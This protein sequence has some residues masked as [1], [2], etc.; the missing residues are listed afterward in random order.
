MAI[1]IKPKPRRRLRA[2]VLAPEH[3]VFSSS[4]M[5]AALTAISAPLMS[6]GSYIVFFLSQ[7]VHN[8]TVDS[9]YRR[10]RSSASPGSPRRAGWKSTTQASSAE[11]A[12][13]SVAW[14][15]AASRRACSGGSGGDRRIVA[16]SL[17]HRCR[18]ERCE[19][20]LDGACDPGTVRRTPTSRSSSVKRRGLAPV[21]GR[22]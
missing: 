14:V 3:Y 22:Q 18:I 16:A 1:R 15:T 6:T 8:R 11:A 19:L 20:A 13:V 10:Q 17:P 5:M 21:N 2:A 12:I 9:C 4:S 7:E